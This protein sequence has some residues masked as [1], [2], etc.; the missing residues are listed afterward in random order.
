V[1]SRPLKD[2]GA[3][4]LLIDLQALKACLLRLPE[5]IS[6][7]ATAS[8]FTKSVNKSCG[9]IETLLKVVNAPLDPPEGFINNY[10]VMVGD[11][12]FSNF[13]KVLDLKGAP[14]V[15]QNNLLDQFLTTTSTR[16]DL[17]T[18]SFLSALDMEPNVSI[19]TSVG[20]PAT[21][22]PI[23]TALATAS[24]ATEGEG[25]FLSSLGSP[26]LSRTATPGSIKGDDT[27]RK[28]GFG[29][30][31]RLLPFGGKRDITPTGS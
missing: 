10:L 5:S 26:P 7:G 11:S 6:E 21:P 31:R 27:P 14:R 12:S 20:T 1:K 16:S 18:T 29:D 28:G 23:P 30:L 22:K 15:E 4:Q 9:R 3:E 13:Q 24:A 8:S 25:G 19:L 17:E 2:K